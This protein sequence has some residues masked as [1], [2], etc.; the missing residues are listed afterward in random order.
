MAY[1][2]WSVTTVMIIVDKHQWEKNEWLGK[3][4]H[5]ASLGKSDK[6]KGGDKKWGSRRKG[7]R[8]R[9]EYLLSEVFSACWS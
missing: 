2:E 6:N 4:G 9:S 8:P 1:T 7:P 5:L 3:K